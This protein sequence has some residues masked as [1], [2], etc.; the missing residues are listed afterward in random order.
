MNI[1]NLKRNCPICGAKEGEALHHISMLLPKT[2]PIQGEYDVVACCQ[3]G[4]IYADVE[5]T[6]ENYNEYYE[7]CNMYSGISELKKD[8]YDKTRDHRID[9]LEKYLDKNDRILDIGCGSGD[10]LKGL[11]K[12]SFHNIYGIDPSKNAII[13]LHN[14]GIDGSVGNIFDEVPQVLQGEFDVVCCTAVLEHIYDIKQAVLK[15]CGYMKS[16]KGKLFVDVPAVEGF[17]KYA[18]KIPNYFNH[19]HINYFSLQSLDNLFDGVGM[20][21]INSRDDSYF[22]CNVKDD[23]AEM[24]IQGLYAYSQEKEQLQKDVDSVASVKRYFEIVEKENS[25]EI[26]A[27]QEVIGQN[28]KIIIWGTGSFAMWLLRH[29]PEVEHSLI[30]FI[31]NNTEKQGTMLCG[32]PVHSSEYLKEADENAVIVI[33]SMQNAQEIAEQIDNMQINREYLILK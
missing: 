20:I 24:A 22:V 13:S 25:K 23:M 27:I 16:G 11:K 9:F 4:F 15:I 14:E 19:E 10:L 29:V 5:G 8:A 2:F 12:K 17:E 7:K 21:R 28:R 6:Q 1:V 30:Y 32:K 3:C 31:D 26:Q 33:C 18:A